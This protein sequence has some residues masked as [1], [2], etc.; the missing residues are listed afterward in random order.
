MK[1]WQIFKTWLRRA[2]V[3]FT[4]I[5]LL[6]IFSN[7]LMSK[8]GTTISTMQFLRILP[9]GLCMSAAGMLYQWEKMPRWA[10]ILSHYLLTVLSVFLCLYL[11]VS[12]S[13]AA[14][15]LLMLVL[16]SVI[17]WVIIGL[18]LLITSRIRKLMEED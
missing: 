1:F 14:S 13:Q 8:G 16:L 17:Y 12:S 7:L 6:L 10:G 18:I 11:P 2:C 3:Y 9:V 5:A 15:K 4:V